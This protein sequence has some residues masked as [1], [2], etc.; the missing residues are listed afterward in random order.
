MPDEH[1]VINMDFPVMARKS[2]L[3]IR[4]AC[5]CGGQSSASQPRKDGLGLEFK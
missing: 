2:L 4:V 5:A 3:Y 1:P